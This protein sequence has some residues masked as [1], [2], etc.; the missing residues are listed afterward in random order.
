MDNLALSVSKSITEFLEQNEKRFVV[1]HTLQEQHAKSLQEFQIRIDNLEKKC[2]ELV[3]ENTNLRNELETVR[4]R[5]EET[6][7]DMITTKSDLD[8]MQ[9]SVN[10]C[11]EWVRLIT[12][13][14]S[15]V[16]YLN[17]SRD[18][19]EKELKAIQKN[20]VEFNKQ[21][22]RQQRQLNATAATAQA[23]ATA[24]Y[25]APIRSPSTSSFF[26]G[27]MHSHSP[28][29][30]YKPQTNHHYHKEDLF[31]SIEANDEISEMSEN[32]ESLMKEV[33]VLN[34]LHRSFEKSSI[35]SDD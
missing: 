1:Q 15:Q 13:L 19:V 14:T 35:C 8:K 24:P 34:D 21:I 33:Q 3:T 26:N 29:P 30:R 5:E 4:K 31:G 20:Q 11:N 7:K 27:N 23:A 28:M 22:E 10:E 17:E 25:R 12:A 2:E 32:A 6:V 9:A 18:S 16:Q